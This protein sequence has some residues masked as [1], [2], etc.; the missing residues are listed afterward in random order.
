M[1]AALA[2]QKVEQLRA[3]SWTFDAAG[4]PISDTTT[5]TTTTPERPTG[6]TGLMASPPGALDDNVSGYCDFL[7][8]A[9][10][11]LGSGSSLPSGAVFVRRWS[12]DRLPTGD[13]LVIQVSVTP[14]VGS[15]HH[16]PGRA[17]EEARLVD[18]K[19]RKSR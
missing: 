7:D 4:T 15:R 2:L 11:S 8:A 18:I 12:I 3:L 6:G 19:T 9:G 5:D 10:A 16:V 1:S 13:A 17:T 14:V